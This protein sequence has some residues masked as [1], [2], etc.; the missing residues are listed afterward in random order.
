MLEYIEADELV[1]V[2]PK[3]LRIFL[4]PGWEQ[5][6]K[7]ERKDKKRQSEDWENDAREW[8]MANDIFFSPDSYKYHNDN[9]NNK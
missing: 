8:H 1:E 4:R 9:N 6:R 2:T 3:N 5:R 7:K